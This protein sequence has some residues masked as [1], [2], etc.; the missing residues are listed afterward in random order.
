MIGRTDGPSS[1]LDVDP[2]HYLAYVEAL[3]YEDEDT[4]RE[5]EKLYDADRPVR[6][7]KPRKSGEARRREIDRFVKKFG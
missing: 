3:A 5:L 2:V 4:A 1:L 6:P 7:P